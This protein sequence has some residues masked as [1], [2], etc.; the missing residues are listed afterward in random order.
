MPHVISIFLCTNDVF[1]YSHIQLFAGLCAYFDAENA[2]D[3]SLA[4]SMGI[5][6]ENLIVSRPNSAENLLSAVDTL[7]KSG[8]VDVIV[9][10]SVSELFLFWFLC[11]HF[12]S[13]KNLFVNV[14]F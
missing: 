13:W 12:Y 5:D 14:I 11:S 8:S 3:P 2:M 1:L 7:T 10:D 9:V 6:I 4:K